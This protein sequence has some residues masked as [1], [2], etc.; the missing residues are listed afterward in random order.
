MSKE[1]GKDR[2]RKIAAFRSEIRR[3]FGQLNREQG[4]IFDAANAALFLRSRLSMPDDGG[5]RRENSANHQA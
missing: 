1:S 2:G 5:W 4:W 3:E